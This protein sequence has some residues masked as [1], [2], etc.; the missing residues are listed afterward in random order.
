MKRLG[1]RCSWFPYLIVLV[2]FAS[3]SWAD[4]CQSITLPTEIKSTLEKEFVGWEV[5]T[6]ELLTSPDER[7]LWNEDYSSECPGIISG[8]F[9]GQH[10]E[11]AVNLVRG[12]GNTLEQQIVI[13][14]AAREGFTKAVLIPPSHI[15]V[16]SVLRKFAPGVYRSAETGRS[17]KVAF[18]TIGVSR[19]WAGAAVYYW[20]GKRFRSVVTSV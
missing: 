6:P 20:D 15:T 13:F 2:T 7:Q 9:R 14:E 16:V 5:V 3:R 18:D 4:A 19:I 11:Y 8:H 12:S 1:T 17:V 10:V